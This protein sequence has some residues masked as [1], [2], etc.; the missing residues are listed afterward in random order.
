MLAASGADAGQAAID[1]D[2]VRRHALRRK[3]ALEGRAH[4]LAVQ[5]VQA[6]DRLGYE[7]GK[8]VFER[9]KLTDFA[10]NRSVKTCCLLYCGHFSMTAAANRR[11]DIPLATRIAS[12]IDVI[13]SYFPDDHYGSNE[14]FP[15]ARCL[16][17]VSLSTPKA[18]FSGV[19]SPR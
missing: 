4:R 13:I 15:Q 17:Q 7:L 12:T 14:L 18:A 2:V 9:T 11:P 8:M 19:A 1:F 10:V 3:A 5:Q 16:V 6:F